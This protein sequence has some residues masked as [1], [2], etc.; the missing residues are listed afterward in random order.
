MPRI[1]VIVYENGVEADQSQYSGQ[2]LESLIEQ[3]E[4]V[5]NKYTVTVVLDDTESLLVWSADAAPESLLNKEIPI[6]P[7]KFGMRKWPKDMRVMFTRPV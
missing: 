3:I 1:Q 4:S 7:R 6:T 2:E 5:W